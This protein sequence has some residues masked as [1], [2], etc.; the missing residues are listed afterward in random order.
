MNNTRFITLIAFAT[1]SGACYATGTWTYSLV[2]GYNFGGPGIN[3]WDGQGGSGPQTTA[4]AT[5]SFTGMDSNGQTQTMTA[6]GQT[7]NSAYFGHLHVYAEMQASNTYYNA[8]NPRYQAVDGTIDESGSPDGVC[9]LGFSGFTDTLHYGGELQ[10]GYRAR[11]IFHVDGTNS[12]P[13]CLADMAFQIQGYSAESF[14]SFGNGF[15]SEIWATQTY[16]INGITPQD[17][18]VQ[19]SNQV[20]FD[21]PNFADGS[22]L[23]GVSDYSSTLTL[24]HIE[25]VDGDGNLVSGVTVT[26][27]SGTNYSVVPE[28]ATLAVLSAG[29][30]ALARRRRP[31]AE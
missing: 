18:S 9:S 12:G 30:L 20:V 3:E 11:Y 4:T 28:P 10:A 25:V 21:L 31:R 7:I 6:W 1:L 16:D 26:S 24:D 2:G 29:L 23:H 22:S 8:S 14:F 27:D 17:V 13:G 15:N 5:H 19:F